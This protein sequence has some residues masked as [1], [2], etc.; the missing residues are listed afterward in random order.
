MAKRDEAEEMVVREFCVLHERH[1]YGA[2]LVTKEAWFTRVDFVKGD[3]GVE[4]ELDWRDLGLNVLA[5]R[6]DN[7][8]F[9]KGYYVEGGRPCRKHIVSVARERMWPNAPPTP[10]RVRPHHGTGPREL[11]EAARTT[12]DLLVGWLDRLEGEWPEIWK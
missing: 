7:G 9:P 6:L 5:V 3:I 8:H 1:G 10:R 11:A 12:R 4:L 2:P